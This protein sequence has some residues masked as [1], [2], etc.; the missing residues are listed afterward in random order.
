MRKFMGLLKRVVPIFLMVGCLLLPTLGFPYDTQPG[1]FKEF[2]GTNGEDYYS[3]HRNPSWV[4][5]STSITKVTCLG[6][7]EGFIPSWDKEGN[8]IPKRAS[9]VFGQEGSGFYVGNGYWVTNFHVINPDQVLIQEGKGFSYIVHPIKITSRLITIG[10][11][12]NIGSV[13]AEL[14]WCDQEQ[15][16]ALLRVIGNWEASVDPGYR[17]GWTRYEGYDILYP[18]MSVACIVA[19]RD[20]DGD[21]VW[22]FEVRYGQIV[23]GKPVLP[24]QLP[25]DI[26]PWFNMN[27]VTMTTMIYPGDSG[28][29]VFAFI[30]GKPVI[31][32]V[33]RALAGYYDWQTGI[34]YYYSYFTRID[35]VL[36]FT[37]EVK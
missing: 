26:L 20:D 27:D 5:V 16:L 28:S 30:D 7:A 29:P 2:G 21:K 36:L 33:A 3:R 10:Q 4:D 13:P 11:N 25:E 31:I 23:A 37:L 17:P 32:G 14:I 9:G 12:S 18:G 6:T 1:N 22:T 15:D 8:Y 24:G 34:I 19:M 35:R